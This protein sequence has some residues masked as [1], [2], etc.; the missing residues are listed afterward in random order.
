MHCSLQDLV[1][2]AAFAFLWLVSSSAWGK[3]LTDVKWATSPDHLAESCKSFCKAEEFPSMG[4]LNAS[5]VSDGKVKLHSFELLQRPNKY[6]V[7]LLVVQE[8]SGFLITLQNCRNLVPSAPGLR[9]TAEMFPHVVAHSSGWGEVAAL[10]KHASGKVQPVPSGEHEKYDPPLLG[11]LQYLL[12]EWRGKSKSFSLAG[13][14]KP[15]VLL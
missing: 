2:T 11:L 9:S 15:T 14:L 3:G 6:R 8:Q 13:V 4:R 7:A 5:V 12:Q 10:Y 1:V